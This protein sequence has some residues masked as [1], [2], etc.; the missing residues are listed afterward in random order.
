MTELRELDDRELDVVG[1]GHHSVNI[2][3]SVNI[4]S[5]IGSQ[6]GQLNAV[7]SVITG[8]DAVAVTLVNT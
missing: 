2:G 6:V 1:G 7:A 3:N 8:I 5:I 4:G